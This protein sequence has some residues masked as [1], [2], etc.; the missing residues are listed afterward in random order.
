[1]R[2]LRNA[3]F[4]QFLLD[5]STI[6]VARQS[7]LVLVHAPHDTLLHSHLRASRQGRGTGR[8]LSQRNL[9]SSPPSQARENN[10]TALVPLRQLL[11]NHSVGI[12][13]SV[14]T[15]DE[16]RGASRSA[17]DVECPADESAVLVGIEDDVGGCVEGDA[18]L[19]AL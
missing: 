10:T 11:R 12:L 4:E 16:R 9:L 19:E 1:M 5:R 2:S 8:R 17:A 15:A 6:Y 7:S 18:V 3:I 14:K 13:A